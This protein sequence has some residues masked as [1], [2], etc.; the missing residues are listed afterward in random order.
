MVANVPWS[1]LGCMSEQLL[2]RV[3]ETAEVLGL[4][5][6]TVYRLIRDGDLHP[7]KVGRATRIPADELERY[8]ADLRG[9]GVEAV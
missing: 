7:V 9:A 8:V 1:T 4:G 5:R 6:T 3:E 2:L